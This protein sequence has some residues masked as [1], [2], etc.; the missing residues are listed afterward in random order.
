MRLMLEGEGSSRKDRTVLVFALVVLAGVALIG[1]Y[2]TVYPSTSSSN[3]Q[4]CTNQTTVS[5]S[6]PSQ[7]GVQITVGGP[8]TTTYHPEF[9]NTTEGTTLGF[10][11][12]EELSV[13]VHSNVTADVSLGLSNVPCGVWAEF[14]PSSLQDV[15]PAG[16]RTSLLLAGAMSLLPQT[17]DPRNV[18]L[19]IGARTG[20]GTSS[21]IALP[22]VQQGNLTVLHSP[23]PVIEPGVQTPWGGYTRGNTS[24]VFGVVY[25]P[26]NPQQ[27]PTL[28]VTLSA[29]GLIQNGSLV[30]LPSWMRVNLPT[31]SFN[32]NASEPYYFEVGIATQPA[33]F[34]SYTVFLREEVNGQPFTDNV[35]IETHNPP[36]F[37]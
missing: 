9:V 2:A 29:A 23:G 37:G 19:I 26:A 8:V 35:T 28:S 25:D 22:V 20:G 18:S 1:V 34:G 10:I 30:P 32:L 27:H 3:G 11:G 14:D 33:H 15:G 12:W 4:S 16:A 6:F 24:D 21:A 36:S 31:P 13:Y 5:Q 17:S 7:S